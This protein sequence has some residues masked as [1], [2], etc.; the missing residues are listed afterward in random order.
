MKLY[1]GATLLDTQSGTQP[2]SS[3]FWISW[4]S[5]PAN[6]FG[7]EPETVSPTPIDF[8]PVNAGT[9]AGRIDVTIDQ[10]SV[11]NILTGDAS[12]YYEAQFWDPINVE[13]ISPSGEDSGGYGNFAPAINI[14]LNDAAGPTPDPVAAPEPGTVGL[15][16][17]GALAV[18]TWRRRKSG[19]LRESEF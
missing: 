8:G 10:G 2:L 15:V 6:T 9:F 16:G 19:S 11:D 13:L 7:Y 4:W 5:D 18:A 12:Q 3:A 14:S 17:L 1:N